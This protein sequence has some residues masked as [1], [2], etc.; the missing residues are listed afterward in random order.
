M[1]T[2]RIDFDNEAHAVVHRN[3]QGLRAAHPAQ[4]GRQHELALQ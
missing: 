2:R 3:R 1:R 4:A